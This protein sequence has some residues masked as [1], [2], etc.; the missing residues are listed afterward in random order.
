M[1][2]RR[3]SDALEKWEALQQARPNFQDVLVQISHSRQMMDLQERYSRLAETL[4]LAEQEAQEILAVDKAFP[5]SE[6]VF[7][8]LEL[9]EDRTKLLSPSSDQPPAEGG[10]EQEAYKEHTLSDFSKLKM[11]L[12]VRE[13]M[14]YGLGIM[15]VTTWYFAKYGIVFLTE[16]VFICVVVVVI[17]MNWRNI[18]TGVQVWGRRLTVSGLIINLI[19]IIGL[20]FLRPF[21]YSSFFPAMAVTILGIYLWNRKV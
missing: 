12:K 16:S 6:A 3:F 4:K 7:K 15:S 19:T 20:I 10:L 2:Q 21:Y 18:S 17:R 8:H 11:R 13:G 1:E 5:D 9:K 14:L